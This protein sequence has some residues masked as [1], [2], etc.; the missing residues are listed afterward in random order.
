MQK[1]EYRNKNTAFQ[2]NNHGPTINEGVSLQTSTFHRHL[3]NL[4]EKLFLF[5]VNRTKGNIFE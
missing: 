1:W 5:S 3:L 4:K 2:T